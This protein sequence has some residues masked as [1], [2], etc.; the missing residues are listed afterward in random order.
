MRRR[1]GDR[2][3]R[4]HGAV[5]LINWNE[6][7]GLIANWAYNAGMEEN[8]PACVTQS[9][10]DFRTAWQRKTGAWGTV[11]LWTPW[12][13]LSLPF[14]LYGYRI[15]WATLAFYFDGLGECGP[16]YFPIPGK[17]A[18]DQTS[19]VEFMLWGMLLL[20]GTL[21]VGWLVRAFRP[22]Q[23]RAQKSAYALPLCLIAGGAL[24]FWAAS[25]LL[26]VPYTYYMGATLPRL[27]G[28]VTCLA[29]LGGGGLA[30]ERLLRAS[31]TAKRCMDTIVGVT[32]A[33]H[34]CVLFVGKGVPEIA[35]FYGVIV[36]GV[37]CIYILYMRHNWKCA[38][39]NDKGD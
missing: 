17:G 13:V 19:I 21:A 29:A 28:V 31:S 10:D 24:A 27:M 15:L 3:R 18:L 22:V 37:C 39:A 1:A 16:H 9:W 2:K 7:N 11:L 34:V 33:L 25:L 36:L 38:H 4:R 6:T 14:V 32:A 8:K 26:V 30:L 5:C 35:A 20:L 12:F 23:T